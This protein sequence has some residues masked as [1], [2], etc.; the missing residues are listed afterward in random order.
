MVEGLKRNVFLLWKACLIPSKQCDP[1]RTTFFSFENR[2]NVHYIPPI[3]IPPFQSQVFSVN[4]EAA[5][6]PE[7]Q[8]MHFEN[9][10]KEGV[11]QKTEKRAGL[12]KGDGYLLPP[13]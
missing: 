5:I 4:D 7:A 11:R 6:Q 2:I 3:S 1:Q 8:E 10:N 13:S 12:S 9:M